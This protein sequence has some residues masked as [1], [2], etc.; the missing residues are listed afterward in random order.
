MNIVV[1]T[2]LVPDT[3]ARLSISGDRVNLSG[4]ELV[5]F[6]GLGTLEAFNTDGLR[7]LVR[8]MP[9]VPHMAERTL[10]YPPVFNGMA[11]AGGRLFVADEGGAVSC[12]GQ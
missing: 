10:R 11:A 1:L 4:V 7:T 5:V 8:T 6:S 9:D 3:E 12:F 2:K